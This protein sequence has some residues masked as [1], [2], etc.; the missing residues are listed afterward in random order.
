MILLRYLK[1]VTFRT[2]FALFNY[3]YYYF[4]TFKLFKNPASQTYYF[5]PNFFTKRSV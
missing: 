1:K 2:S 4:I 3:N 5:L